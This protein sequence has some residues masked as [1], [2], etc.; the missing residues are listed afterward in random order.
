MLKE[1]SYNIRLL[2]ERI[3]Y[4]VSSRRSAFSF[5]IIGVLVILLIKV[6][7]SIGCKSGRKKLK[8]R[9][10]KVEHISTQ[11]RNGDQTLKRHQAGS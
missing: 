6:A 7:A 3:S 4:R 1:E 8:Q 10:L 5:F 9:D 11:I 2:S